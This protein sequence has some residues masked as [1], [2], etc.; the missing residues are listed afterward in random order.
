M[1]DYNGLLALFIACMNLVLVLNILVFAEKNT[2]IKYIIFLITLFVLDQFG[3]FIN[4][5]FEPAE[6]ILL[7]IKLIVMLFIP[8]TILIIVWNIHGANAKYNWITFVV[9]IVLSIVYAVS[10]LQPEVIS[11]SPGSAA[12]LFPFQGITDAY[13]IASLIL[14]AVILYSGIVK[15]PDQKK[16]IIVIFTGLVLAVLPAVIASLISNS[17]YEIKESLFGKTSVTLSV[18]LTYYSLKKKSEI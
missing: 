13:F 4:C 1:D 7:F 10:S 17:A 3:E 6:S 11:C 16:I 9:P 18:T 15:F 8:A 14:S 12:Y 2:L 5:Y